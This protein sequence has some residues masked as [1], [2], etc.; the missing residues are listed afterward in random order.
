[1]YGD[2]KQMV[3]QANEEAE[4]QAT[5][6]DIREMSVTEL[7]IEVA[8]LRE[9]CAQLEI[10]LR[11]NREV[12]QPIQPQYIPRVGG[13]PLNMGTGNP[14]INPFT[15]YCSENIKCANNTNEFGEPNVK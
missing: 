1:M 11:E 5:Q 10:R 13:G 2:L 14:P 12:I 8:T 4:L 3:K 15:T 7:Q 6:K 9:R